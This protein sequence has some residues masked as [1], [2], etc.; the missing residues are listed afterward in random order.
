MRTKFGWRLLALLA[1]LA[2]VFAACTD[3][4]GE[5]TTTAASTT[6]EATTTTGGEVTTTTGGGTTTTA[7]PVEGFTYK[8]GMFSDMT[9]DNYWAY[10][11]TQADVYN[12]YVLNSKI[13]ALFAL[14]APGLEVVGDLAASDDPGVPADN[15]D[16]TWSVSVQM[17]EDAIWSDGEPITAQ[18]VVF[19]AETVRD[20]ALGGNW[21]GA[22]NWAQED[23]PEALGLTAV[24]AVS[25]YEVKFTW[26]AQPGLAEWP[27][28]EG[29]AAVMPEHFW[30]PVVEEAKG[31]ENP[32]ETLYA[33]S[34]VGG[35]SGGPVIFD[36]REPG[37]FARNV[38][39]PNY[40][41]AGQEITSGGVTYTNGPF[42]ADQTFS[43]YGDQSAAI[44]ALKSGEVDFVF[45][46]L[47]LQRGLL[48]QVTSD[49]N[50][51]AIQNPPMGFRY[52]A[53]NLRREPM[54]SEGFRDAVAFMIDKE[55]ITGSVLQNVAYPV[56]VTMPAAAAA[57]YN[58]ELAEEWIASLRDLTLEVGYDGEPFVNDNGT[59]EDASDDIP[60]NAVANE[61]RLHAAVSALLADGFS[62][63]EG[64]MPQYIPQAG[65][66]TGTKGTLVPG[67]GIMLNGVPVEPIEILCPGPGYDP[68][69]SSF[70]SFVAEALRALGF[71]ATAQFTDFTVLRTVIFSVE[72]GDVPADM[73]IMGW[74]LGYSPIP[75][76]L[77]YFFGSDQDTVTT[78]GFNNPGFN[79]PDFDAAAE[80]Y[81]KALTIEEAYDLWWQMEEIIFDKKPYFLLFDSGIIEAYRSAGIQYPFTE[82]LGGIQFNNGLSSVVAAA[83]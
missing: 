49:P 41:D 73:W 1:V 42:L 37:A 13:Q 56:Y 23:N 69:R 32:L 17:R 66:I 9:T 10:L 30:G 33:A 8:V 3:D 28:V 22:Y 59:T 71:D 14:D 64:Q 53:F 75:D 72:D 20:L 83:E 12:G 36:S 5:T 70:G 65:D 80:A 57:F 7:P 62:W 39:N 60:Y 40:Y 43:I 31:T 29:F 44:L 81:A 24:E 55:Y 50:L 63:P 38:A 79:D 25:D 11:D 77:L 58:E 16:G 78:G 6:S 34:G 47:G 68:L 26:N 46:S 48:D 45:N 15:G 52:L 74:S 18:D 54:S 82:M 21:P 19:T 4:G 27:T 51:T 2:F 61:A 76:Y 35:P 67:S